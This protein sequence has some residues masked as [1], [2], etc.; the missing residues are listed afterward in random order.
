MDPTYEELLEENYELQEEKKALANQMQLLE[1]KRGAEMDNNERRASEIEQLRK[2]LAQAQSYEL[3]VDQLKEE[4][5]VWERKSKQL[6]TALLDKEE[7][8]VS[9]LLSCHF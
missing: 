3:Q 5:D 1:Q 6:E 9:P 8:Y 4:R 7:R 2:N